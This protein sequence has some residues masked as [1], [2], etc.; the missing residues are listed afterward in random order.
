[1]AL[2]RIENVHAGYG[3]VKAL[4]GISLDV[5]EGSIVTLLGANGAGKSTTLKTIS[6]VVRP[7]SGDIKLDGK[8]IV[9][10]SPNEVV[11]RGIVQV[12]EGRKVFKDLTVYENLLMGSYARSDRAGIASDFERI[13]ELFP[14]LKER[15]SQLG[16]SLSG[17]EQ[18][19]L[20]IGRGLMA[21]PRI[22][23]LDEPSLGLAPIIVANIFE[24][25]R[26]LNAETRMT[27]LIVEQNM[28][29]ALKSA[30]FGYV[31]QVGNIVLSGEAEMLRNS[32]ETF[33]SYLGTAH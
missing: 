8:S 23:L 22:L 4:R 25:L 11:N 9:G 7:T 33:D 14:R 24:T 27:M 19:M 29:I 31:M 17:G 6:G 12:P 21:R 30:S 2:L 16:G 20:A 32:K 10:L 18:Q 3:P 13:Y 15:S 26:N 1:M 28:R 5:A